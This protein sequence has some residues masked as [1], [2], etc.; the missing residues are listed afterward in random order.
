MVADS[1]TKKPE[2][3]SRCLMR[4]RLMRRGLMRPRL[5]RRRLM[6]RRRDG[7]RVTVR[8]APP[9]A[10]LPSRELLLSQFLRVLNHSLTRRG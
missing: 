3:I 2:R 4:R 5:L 1:M 8:S 10:L 9:S 6:R 7:L